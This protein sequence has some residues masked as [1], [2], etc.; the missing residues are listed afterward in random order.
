MTENANEIYETVRGRSIRGDLEVSD[1][2]EITGRGTAYMVKAAFDPQLERFDL[3]RLDGELREVSGVEKG[4]LGPRNGVFNGHQGI[5]LRHPTYILGTSNRCTVYPQHV[6]VDVGYLPALFG[7]QYRCA[8]GEEHP[9]NTKET[10]FRA[11]NGGPAA[12][13]QGL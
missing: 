8:C 10:A 4:G 2:F 5:L 9:G 12:N 3:V 7:H 11:P 13:R 1:T 6:M